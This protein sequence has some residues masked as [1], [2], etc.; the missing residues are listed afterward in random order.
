LKMVFIGQFEPSCE[1][2][3]HFLE[4]RS[5]CTRFMK[6]NLICRADEDMCGVFAKHWRSKKWRDS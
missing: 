5:I 3:K 6:N 4:S 2:C 1:S